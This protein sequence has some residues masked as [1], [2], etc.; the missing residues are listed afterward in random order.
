[1]SYLLAIDGGSTAVKAVALDQSGR[2]MASAS[3]GVE[4]VTHAGGRVERDATAMW[5]S[6]TIAI[7][8][9]MTEVAALSE[10]IIGISVTGHGNGL[11]LLDRAGEPLGPA[12]QSSDTRATSLLHRRRES[13][14]EDLLYRETYQR[15]WAGQPT[16]LLP[17]LKTNE[18]DRYRQIGAVLSCKDY[19]R[20]RLTGEVNAELTDASAS[21]LTSITTRSYSP[22]ILELVGIADVAHA[23]PQILQ[24]D[25]RAGSVSEQAA[26]ETG[27]N[28][29]TPVFAGLFDVAAAPLGVGVSAPGSTVAVAGTWNMAVTYLD[30]PIRDSAVEMIS[31]SAVDGYWLAV[32]GSPTSSPNIDWALSVLASPGLGHEELDRMAAS[33]PP[34]SSVPIFHPFLAGSHSNPA[35]RSGFYNL[36]PTHGRAHLVRSVYEGVAF[37]QRYHL[38]RIATVAPNQPIRLTGGV[39]R[40]PVWT[41][42]LADALGRTVEVSSAADATALGAAIVAASG[43]ELFRDIGEAATSLG[44]V[45]TV[46]EP[47]PA[48]SEATNDRYQ[49]YLRLIEELADYWSGEA[50]ATTDGPAHE[51]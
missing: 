6:T 30:T 22:D 9:V 43:L 39:S 47:N 21:G 41:Q 12:I 15:S 42:T 20:F 51:R 7:G 37:A 34:Q 45:A 28:R 48:D 2:V 14:I 16:A 10:Q 5:E 36:M 25:D 31:A 8:E 38:E 32:E 4:P 27:L 17:W 49:A 33:I 24:P 35:A 19:L 46:F 26:V 29:G 18:P 13:G 1:V 50:H 40:S 3:T 11:Y 23:L 44:G